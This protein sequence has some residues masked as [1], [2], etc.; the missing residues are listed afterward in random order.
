MTQGASLDE[1]LGNLR[2]AVDLYMSGEDPARL[3]L[4]PEPRLVMSFETA[5]RPR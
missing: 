3:G 4:V 1:T 5:A 2:E